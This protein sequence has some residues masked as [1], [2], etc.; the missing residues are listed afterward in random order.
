MSPGQLS[1]HV[2]SNNLFTDYLKV[3]A[4]LHDKLYKDLQ[5]GLISGYRLAM[6]T[7]K[8]MSDLCYGVGLGVLLKLARDKVNGSPCEDAHR[9]VNL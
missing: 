7:V 9:A 8:G 1:S 2:G 4:E 3:T 5:R 6:S